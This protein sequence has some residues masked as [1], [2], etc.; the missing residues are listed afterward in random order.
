MS[1]LYAIILVI[2]MH[3]PFVIFPTNEV[4]STFLSASCAR[5]GDLCSRI[6]SSPREYFMK[7]YR[8]ELRDEVEVFIVENSK[9]EH[10]LILPYYESLENAQASL[11][12]DGEMEV[13]GGEILS[14]VDSLLRATN[15]VW[16]VG[17]LITA[18]EI[19]IFNPSSINLR[20][21]MESMNRGNSALSGLLSALLRGGSSLAVSG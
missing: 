9:S 10:N 7:M 11:L 15:L 13:S 17:E 18:G 20:L 5:D 19:D 1:I 21:A 6:K 16:E 14:T 3:S 2:L 12:A 8:V 4:V